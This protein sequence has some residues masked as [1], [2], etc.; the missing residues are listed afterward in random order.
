[1][2]IF[3]IDGQ[4]HDFRIAP[5]GAASCSQ[6]REPL[7][8]RLPWSAAPEGRRERLK[9]ESVATTSNSRSSRTRTE[10]TDAVPSTYTN[11]LY[12]VVFSTKQRRPFIHPVLRDELY[13]YFGGAI[14]GE[15]GT[16]LEIGGM[17]DHVHLLVKLPADLAVASL[18]RTIKANSSK[19]IHVRPDFDRDFAWQT[20]YGAFTVSESQSDRVRKYIKTQE[21]HH[22]KM[23]FQEELLSLLQKNRIEYDERYLWE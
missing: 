20:G 12:H 14:R 1:M 2:R 4:S 8:K 6:W 17:P 21:R 13:P 19:W 5:A 3:S 23:T 10:R 18:L 22:R 15:G 9:L 7:E 11:L 16:L